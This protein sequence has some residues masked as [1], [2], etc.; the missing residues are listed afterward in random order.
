MST[1]TT[2][3]E[4]A[5]RAGGYLLLAQL[6]SDTTPVYSEADAATAVLTGEAAGNLEQAIDDA[7]LL[8]DQNLN[9]VLDMTLSANQT[10]VGTMCAWIALYFLDSRRNPG[11]SSV[12]EKRYNAALKWLRDVGQRRIKV[13]ANPE[14]PEGLAYSTTGSSTY[15]TDGVMSNDALENF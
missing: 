14:S 10:A 3:A 5:K 15:S 6:A 12:H 4:L 11:E 13:A 1:Y 8:I 2:V 9:G 7:S